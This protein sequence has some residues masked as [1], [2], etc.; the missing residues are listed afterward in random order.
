MNTSVM[1][2]CDHGKEELD[3]H[4]VNA[5]NRGCCQDQACSNGKRY[6]SST[7]GAWPKSKFIVIFLE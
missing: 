5:N 1:A 4:I 7:L 6:L 2:T 3:V